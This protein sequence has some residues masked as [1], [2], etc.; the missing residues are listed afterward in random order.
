[1]STFLNKINLPLYLFIWVVLTSL[2]FSTFD[3]PFIWISYTPLIYAI[4]K[5]P[6]KK[7]AN[8]G[9]IFC[10]LYYLCTL[11]WLI[12]FHEI[13]AFFVF[14]IYALYGTI[15]MVFTKYVS[16]RFPK[17]RIIVFPIIWLLFEIIRS[18]GFFGFR[19]NI[20]ADALWKQLIFLQSA[21][22]IGA[23][24]V[25]FIVLL[26]N[27]C[28]AEVLFNS[29]QSIQQ[30]FKK[31]FI[32]VYL[33]L[34]LFLCNLA[35]GISASQIWKDLIDTKLHR[36]KVTLIQP[37]RPGHSSWYQEGETL[38]QKYLDMMRSVSN[39]NP[40]LILQTEIMLSTYFWES[41]DAYGI[42]HPNNQYNKQFIELAKE[43]DTPV[44]ITHFSTDSQRRSYNS[45]T[46]ITYTNESYQTNSY[47]KI[48]IVPF[49]E[50]I[51]GSQNWPWLD[52]LLSSIG[53]AWASP[54][55][56]FTIFTSKNGL[57]FALLICFEDIYAILGRLFVKKGVQYFVNATN[58]GW[59][60]RWKLGAKAPLWQHLAN[61]THTAVS[62]RRSIARSVNT[63][64]TAVVDPMGRMDIAPLKEY[65][66][67]IY[68]T[69]V[70]AMPI[71][72]R[73]LYVLW[74]WL[75]QYIIFFI[76][77]GL[78]ITTLWMDKHSTLLK[79]IL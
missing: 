78:I 31:T 35:Y 45:A 24:G 55:R 54:G 79:R 27:S 51:P 59:A 10:Y 40:D 50:W 57:K 16:E 69:E 2:S 52:N 73:S 4:Y 9:F 33:T 25:S 41:I 38:S 21:D 77:I 70:P 32:P 37:N 6:L 22:I 14:P 34:F 56:T 29:K 46:L 49:G 61:T 17:L 20:P 26:V 30:G 65:E 13:S 1:M 5:F 11:Y 44:M 39:Q 67:G 74:G 23:W 7:I 48:H 76:G 3:L 75:A 47:S 18:I 66:E 72:H 15:A 60:Y 28:I 71:T 64:I 43:L 63:G 53:A 42:D 58:D 68:T 36:E 62:L 19:W 12:A 8:Y